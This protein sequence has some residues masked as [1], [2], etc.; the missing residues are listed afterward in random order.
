MGSKSDHGSRQQRI[1]SVTKKLRKGYENGKLT[2]NQISRLEAIGFAFQAKPFVSL[3]EADPEIAKEWDYERNAPLTPKNV[4]KGSGRAV[5]WKCSKCGWRW[6]KSVGLR[7][8]PNKRSGCPLCSNAVLVPGKNDLGTT[9]PDIAKRWHPTKNGDLTPRDV[10][11]GSSKKVWWKCRVCGYEFEKRVCDMT[12]GGVPICLNC[13]NIGRF[14]GRSVNDNPKLIS[15]FDSSLNGGIDPRAIA[16][17]SEK[18]YVWKCP[19]GHVFAQQVDRLARLKEP[20]PICRNSK[21]LEGRSLSEVDPPLSKE[22]NYEKNSGLTPKDIV[23]GSSKKVWWKCPTCGGEWEAVVGVRVRE[24][25]KCPY[26]TNH[27]LL[28][29][30]NDVASKR[31]DIAA[32]WHPTRNGDLTPRDVVAGSKKRVWWR[33]WHEETQTWHEW[34]NSPREMQAKDGKCPYCTNHALLRG[35]NDVA[36]KRPDIAAQWHP[37][38]NGDLT[39]RDV[40]A[41]SG[42]KVWWKCPTCGGEWFVSL[43]ARIVKKTGCPHC[44]NAKPVVCVETG[45]CYP[46]IKHA[47]KAAGLK[48]SNHIG[49]AIKRK[50]TSGGYHWRYAT[51]E[52]IAA[53]AGGGL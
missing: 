19:K 8:T 32:Q 4:S 11:A 12:S 50:G 3:A 38:R 23:A 5:W 6:K 45:E 34:E 20:C 15:F 28:R 9:C 46:S 49:R 13:Q 14:K 35:F 36:S 27:A 33:H 24:K 37:T 51:E 47:A 17:G 41:G 18:E 22:W 21:L 44:G 1:Y 43:S 53:Q 29:G 31:P 48:Y 25:T 52:E 7:T 30:F 2:E 26:C 10:T 42:K 40:T 16:E 39:P